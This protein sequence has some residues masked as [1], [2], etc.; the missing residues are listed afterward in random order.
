MNEQSIQSIKNHLQKKEAQE[1][2][3]SNILSIYTKV[4]VPIGGV[5]DLFG[6]TVNQLRKWEDKGLLKP[7]RE[8]R[9]RH[10]SL[11]DLEKLAVIKELIDAKY[12]P[13]N[14]PP[15]IDSI[16]DQIWL[17]NGK[18]YQIQQSGLESEPIFSE[19]EDPYLH[20]R[21]VHAREQLFW[22]YFASHALRLSLRLICE[23]VTRNRMAGLILPLSQ[24]VTVNDIDN[25]SD[26]QKVGESLI[27]WL[28]RSGSSHT[29]I[30]ATPL[31]EYASDYRLYRL[32]TIE[33][34]VPLEEDI[35]GDN[36][37]LFIDRR[38]NISSLTTGAVK[39]IRRLLTPLYEDVQFTRAC[40][41]QGMRDALDPATDIDSNYPDYILDGLAE[42]VVRLGTNSGHRK[43][44][45]CCILLPDD[46]SLPLQ[47]RSL[48]VR[49]QSAHAPHK[50]GETFISPNQTT[51]SLSLR[52]YQSGQ[53]IYRPE[54]Y[55]EDS[56]IALR[57]L[58]NPRSAIAIPAGRNSSA[59]EAI[60]YVVSDEPNAFS[61]DDQRVLRLLGR[62]VEELLAT[63]R[64][65]LQ[66]TEKLTSL[67]LAPEVNDAY[68]EKKRLLTENEFVED[69]ETLL[70]N[71][72]LSKV[73]R[74][75]GNLHDDLPAT[76]GKLIAKSER[77]LNAGISII[78]IDL[79]HQSRL[80]NLYGDQ[81]SRNLQTVVGLKLL[82]QLPQI[83]TE[84]TQYKLYRICADR[85][86]LV[87]KDLSLDE[88]RRQADRIKRR[89]KDT[90]EVSILHSMNEET[91]Q[92]NPE[93]MQLV[94]ISVH[95]GV[96]YYEY[97]KLDDL[98]KKYSSRTAVG[99]VRSSISRDIDRALNLGRI[100]GGDVVMSWDPDKSGYIRWSSNH[101]G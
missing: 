26:L 53:S 24:V 72:H 33:D 77:S 8:G 21:I 70:S 15:E 73:G 37:L 67:I 34:G 1:R 82:E 10:Y 4:S 13:G 49:A 60:L 75:D 69:I 5:V 79:D 86:Y 58:E 95:V 71:I 47:K 45:F 23:N 93:S 59:P 76:E 97:T 74:D 42:L 41:G 87:T 14:I 85:F 68:F 88:I 31:F 98:L 100:E 28:S 65:R 27:G 9:H 96:S 91:R 25:I 55:E 46:T 43:W 2:I 61:I 99:N 36:T 35:P 56:T 6:F 50:V 81:F 80:A 7:Q 44:R 63:Y 83:F 89:L 18:Q 32:Q 94:S 57:E 52:A 40:F 16:W 84:F 51:I 38:A 62:A 29:L 19:P 12:S 39:A 78:S 22:R 3:R 101:S 17:S 66:T 54:I 64:I 11:K 20:R 30:T 48:V 90:V 92:P